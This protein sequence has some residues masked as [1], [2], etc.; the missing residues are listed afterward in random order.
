[1]CRLNDVLTVVPIICVVFLRSFGLSYDG[2][3]GAFMSH[4]V[5]IKPIFTCFFRTFFFEALL[6]NNLRCLYNIHFLPLNTAPFSFFPDLRRLVIWLMPKYS[7]HP[8][9]PTLLS[10]QNY[11]NLFLNTAT[12]NFKQAFLLNLA[13]TGNQIQF[14]RFPFFISAK[15]LRTSST[16]LS[17][18]FFEMQLDVINA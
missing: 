2:I 13:W 6:K 14:Y 11:F 16:N 18:M 3:P 7:I 1:M 5:I 4:V 17:L 8:S 9:M 10:L 15:T 12:R